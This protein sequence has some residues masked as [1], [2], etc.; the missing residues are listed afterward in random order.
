MPRPL[1]WRARLLRR[2]NGHRERQVR[3]EPVQV[4]QVAQRRY[5]L[6]AEREVSLFDRRRDAVQGP[7]DDGVFLEP[8]PQVGKAKQLHDD[9]LAPEAAFDFA[10]NVRELLD[11]LAVGGARGVVDTTA[12]TLARMTKRG[13]DCVGIWRG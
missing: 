4:E 1:D 12:Q 10:N 8:L 2:G 13:A 9:L 7:Q 6:P 11:E 5:H 3:G